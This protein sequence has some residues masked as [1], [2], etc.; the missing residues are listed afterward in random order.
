MLLLRAIRTCWVGSDRT[1]HSLAGS[2]GSSL[3]VGVAWL[4]RPAAVLE[5][6]VFFSV[7][8]LDLLVETR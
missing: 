1:E 4:W 7:S 5:V 2:W 8:R 6:V 3:A